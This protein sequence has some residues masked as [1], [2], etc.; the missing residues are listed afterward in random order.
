MSKVNKSEF[1]CSTIKK[2]DKKIYNAQG[3]HIV[4]ASENAIIDREGNEIAK[5]KGYKRKG[6]RK[7]KVFEAADGE[8]L[9]DKNKL[10]KNGKTFG[11]GVSKVR[12]VPIFSIISAIAFMFSMSIVSLNHV[13]VEEDF[14]PVVHIVDINGVWN[15]E[16]VVAMFDNTIYPGKKGS[17]KFAVVNTNEYEIKYS[18]SLDHFYDG[19][20]IEVFPLRYK[21]RIGNKYLCDDWLTAVEM[22]FYDI[23]LFENESAVFTVEWQWPFESGRDYFDTQLGI[24]NGVYNVKLTLQAELFER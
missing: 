5:F 20:Q 24:F 10:S 15:A 19:K 2:K 4:T 12:Y 8:Y 22:K 17:Y 11:F 16:K 13:H 21:L 14:K 7:I 1:D 3:Q 18:F 6:L 9:L 23:I